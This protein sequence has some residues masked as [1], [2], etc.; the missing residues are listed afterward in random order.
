[1]EI[2][3]YY[4]LYV[5]EILANERDDIVSELE[6]G[7]IRSNLYMITLAQGERNQ[8]EFFSTNRLKQK[9]FLDAKIFVV[10]IAKEYGGTVR[11]V[12]HIVDEIYQEVA[13]P[14]VREH[15]LRKQSISLKGKNKERRTTNA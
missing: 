9:V 6:K 11:L 4:D 8:L 1:M 12:Q 10:G 13:D 5:E 15:L 14:H 7:E 3:C 2:T